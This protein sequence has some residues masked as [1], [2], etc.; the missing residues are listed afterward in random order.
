MHL[1]TQVYPTVFERLGHGPE[2]PGNGQLAARAPG[3]GGPPAQGHDG[4]ARARQ[5]VVG[6]VDQPVCPE[7]RPRNNLGNDQKLAPMPPN[8]GAGLHEFLERRG[9]GANRELGAR[10]NESFNGAVL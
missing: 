1:A 10:G 9:P 5:L 6:R 4:A 7:R 8:A 2:R 3:D